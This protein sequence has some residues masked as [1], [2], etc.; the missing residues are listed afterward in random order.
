[1]KPKFIGAL[2]LAA[3]VV[4]SGLFMVFTQSSQVTTLSGYLNQESKSRNLQAETE[5]EIIDRRL[6]NALSHVN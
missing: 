4:L 5:L 3:V 1:M 6:K 2:I